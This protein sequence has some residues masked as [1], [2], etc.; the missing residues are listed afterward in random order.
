MDYGSSLVTKQGERATFESL[1]VELHNV[2]KFFNQEPAV[3]GVYL[4]IRQGEFFSILGPSGCGKTTMLRL[5]AGFEKA[6]AGKVVIQGHS[7]TDV[8]P[9]RRPVNTVFQS[10]ALFNHLNVWD[11]V[12][13]GLRLKKLRKAEIESRV[14]QALE[15][16]KMEGLRSRFPNQLSGGQQQ[17]VALARA[18]VNRPA[19]LLLDEPLGA[20]DLK[21]R[22]QMQ[23]ELSSLHK[24]LG[25]TFIMVTHDQEEA[26]SLSD[27]IAVMNQGKIEQIGTPSE[28][29]EEPRTVFVADFI[30]DTNLF[31][32]EIAGVD[33]SF[34]KVVTKKG[35]SIVV[36]RQ[37]DTPT[38]IS[39]TVVISV[40]PEKIQLS[41]YKPSL[42]TN[43]FEGRLV[44]IMYLG[45]HVNYIVQLTN[46]VRVT[47]LQPGTF[48]NLPDR[49]T[50]IYAWWAQGDCQ[51]LSPNG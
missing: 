43:C 5:I 1:D 50:P 42:Q 47:V 15:L 27:R 6:D 16:V 44:N 22:K 9:Y 32:G 38:E 41:L 3:N 4:D 12:A 45:T 11:N 34:V 46:G 29:Y 20:L 8:P 31:E 21:L 40:R 13:F 2:F 33:A 36:T 24:Q 30:G 7:M 48:G 39:Q 19:L 26:L 14:K 49:E 23:V 35:L 37:Q 25:L 28:I 10:Y 51:A 17:R 18:L